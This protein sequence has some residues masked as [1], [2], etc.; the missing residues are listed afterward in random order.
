MA[1]HDVY[2]I[3]IYNIYIYMYIY[4]YKMCYTGVDPKQCWGIS[5]PPVIPQ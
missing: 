1:V 4:V 5:D 2:I 3:Y